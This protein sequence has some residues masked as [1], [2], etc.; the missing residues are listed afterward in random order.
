VVVA[1][2]VWAPVGRADAS[3]AAGTTAKP[4]GTPT[5]HHF[6]GERGVGALFPPGAA[7]HTCTA[8]VVDSPAKDVLITAAHCISGKAKGFVFVPGYRNGV[9]PFG[10]WTVVAAY[11]PRGWL[12]HQDP[13]LDVAFL[14]VAP[15]EVNGRPQ[16]IETVTGGERLGAAPKSG[17]TVTVPAYAVGLN[18]EQLTCTAHVYCRGLFP[19][20]NSD[21][22]VDGTSGSPWLERS[23]AGWVVV[24]VIGG[25]HHGGCQSW[26]SYSSPF[27]AASSRAESSAARSA[28]GSTFP[29]TGSDGCGTGL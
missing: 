10:A 18:D 7:L 24:G 27:G 26:T 9:E 6:V 28:P 14:K 15:H 17:A 25:L 16:Q 11:G 23:W 21:P 8:S 5:A 12:T 1:V 19:S 4:P 3:S 22:Y 2:L 20:F 29:P 13:R